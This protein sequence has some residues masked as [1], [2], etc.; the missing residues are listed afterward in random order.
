MTGQIIL[1]VAIDVEPPNFND[2]RGEFRR[3]AA[4]HVLRRVYCS[5]RDEQDFAGMKRHRR[6]SIDLI[7]KRAFDGRFGSRKSHLRLPPCGL[8]A[9]GAPA[10]AERLRKVLAVERLRLERGR[11]GHARSRRPRRRIK[12]SA[13]NSFGRAECMP[14]LVVSQGYIPDPRAY[15]KQSAA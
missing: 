5:G 6:P 8:I 13:G 14:C 12:V 1:R 4:A 10:D 15:R 11:S 2:I 9:T 7:L 3:V